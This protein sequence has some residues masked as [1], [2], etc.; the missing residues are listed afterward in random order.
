MGEQ[1]NEPSQLSSDSS[2][3][4]CPHTKPDTNQGDQNG[5]PGLEYHPRD[6]YAVHPPKKSVNISNEA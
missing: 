5:I 4:V 1:D 6:Y 3:S 2:L